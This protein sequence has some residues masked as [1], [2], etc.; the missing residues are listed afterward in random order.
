[1]WTIKIKYLWEPRR[2]SDQY[3]QTLKNCRK[4]AGRKKVYYI[5]KS[6]HK[7]GNSPRAKAKEVRVR[8]VSSCW[9]GGQVTEAWPGEMPYLLAVVMKVRKGRY[10]KPIT[11]HLSWNFLLE[12]PAQLLFLLP[13]EQLTCEDLGLGLPRWPCPSHGKSLPEKWE[14]YSAPMAAFQPPKPHEPLGRPVTWVNKILFFLSRFKMGLYTNQI[15]YDLHFPI[16]WPPQGNS[17]QLLVY[18]SLQIFFLEIIH[19][20]LRWF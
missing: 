16:Y 18:L 15:Y 17:Y 13:L 1:M 11:P 6:K 2:A 14:K 8:T 20:P 5:R 9:V 3:D 19:T 7:K 4:C 10:P 12:L